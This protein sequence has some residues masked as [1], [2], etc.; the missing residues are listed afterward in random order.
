MT[1]EKMAVVKSCLTTATMFSF[2]LIA[3]SSLW[4]GLAEVDWDEIIQLKF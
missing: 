4:R 1:S 3:M 2:L